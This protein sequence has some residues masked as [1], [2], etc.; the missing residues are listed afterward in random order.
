MK[1]KGRWRSISTVNREPC[2]ALT[3][4]ASQE[5]RPL[6][7]GVISP[8]GSLVTAVAQIQVRQKSAT[9]GDKLQ[10]L[11]FPSLPKSAKYLLKCAAHLEAKLEAVAVH[12]GNS[13]LAVC[14]TLPH[15]RVLQQKGKT[16]LSPGKTATYFLFPSCLRVSLPCCTKR[17]EEWFNSPSQKQ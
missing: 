14:F 3:K 12:S 5:R 1:R 9:E 11:F 7:L 16:A 17:A 4:Q 13:V 8:C 2:T 10:K 6:R 15:P